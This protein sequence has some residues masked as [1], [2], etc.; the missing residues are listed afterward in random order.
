MGELRT[1]YGRG[2]KNLAPDFE[3]FLDHWCE[4]TVSA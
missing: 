4:V 3:N 1:R 2:D